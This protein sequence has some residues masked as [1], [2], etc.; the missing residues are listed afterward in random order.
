MSTRASLCAFIASS[1][2]AASTSASTRQQNTAMDQARGPHAPYSPKQI[3]PVQP[4]NQADIATSLWQGHQFS[5]VSSPNSTRLSFTNIHG[6]RPSKTSLQD[7]V[8]DM[9]SAQ[10]SFHVQISG[11]TEHH[12]LPLHDPKMSQQLYESMHSGNS[13]SSPRQLSYQ[14]DS[15]RETSGGRGRLMGGTGI[16]AFGQAA[17]RLEPN[18]KDGDAWDDGAA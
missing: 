17:G 12:H 18:G 10:Q 16:I 4:L 14:F 15:S 6:L 8:R 5:P 9:L 3:G 1:E 13:T 2:A 11:I 7:G